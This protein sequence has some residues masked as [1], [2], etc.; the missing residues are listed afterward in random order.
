MT[1][2]DKHTLPARLAD[3]RETNA[4]LRVLLNRAIAHCLH[5]LR[6][7]IL[8]ELNRGQDYLSPDPQ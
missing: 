7:D 5:S 8:R 6:R 2:P 3:L 1:Y 4:E